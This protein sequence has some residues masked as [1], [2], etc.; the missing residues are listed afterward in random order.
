[1]L[2][3]VPCI[4]Y[5]TTWHLFLK[6]EVGWKTHVKKIITKSLYFITYNIN[7]KSTCYQQ[8]QYSL[9]TKIDHAL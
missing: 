4:C 5:K 7:Y 8:Q 2:I 3:V 1:M 6:A 9:L